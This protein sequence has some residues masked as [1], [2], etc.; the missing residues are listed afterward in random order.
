MSAQLPASRPDRPARSA[1]RS[2]SSG[3][4]S[5]TMATPADYPAIQCLLSDVLE[6]PAPPGF[7]FAQEDPFFE[8]HDRLVLKDG[9]RI[10]AHVHTTRRV[11]QFGSLALPAAGIE[12]LAVA[13]TQ[14]RRGHGTRLLR[15]AECHV[16]GQGALVGLL[17]T[18]IP[19]FFRRAGWALCGGDVRSQAPARAILSE[20]L[21]RRGR[22]LRRRSALAVRCWRRLELPALERLYREN[23]QGAYGPLERTEAYWQWLI[24]R[25]AYDQIYVALDG[26]DLLE[27]EDA[28]A[29]IVGYAV[30]RGERLLE[31][32]TAKDRPGV[33]VRLLVRACRDGIEAN[34]HWITLHAPCDHRLHGLFAQAG[35]R[36]ALA[37]PDR[38]E[39]LMARLLAP[40][41]LLRLWAPVLEERAGA[42]G[43]PREFEL[44][45]VVERRK[46][47][48]VR[49]NGR[50]E[51]SSGRMG[52]SV[53]RMNVADFT[54]LVL[55]RIDWNEAM[56]AGRLVASTA[57]AARLGPVLFPTLP[58]WR[59]PLD[60]LVG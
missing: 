51:A 22:I 23:V 33:A 29:P 37:T 59:P 11:M 18:R 5:L 41:R 14:Q 12:W 60:D 3:A 17:R 30:A 16:A 43:L 20:L 27:V 31:L 24:R 8:P 15:A 13:P 53:L 2:G 45:L 28:S 26:P 55:G 25:Q 42:G 50:V 57:L 36:A 54:R 10:V 46:F 1:D 38:G 9:A 34:R 56:G 58:W 44:G 19:H 48:L 49:Q 32:F 35:G 6:R 47:V 40:L 21:R 7:R 39:V 4:P 52:R